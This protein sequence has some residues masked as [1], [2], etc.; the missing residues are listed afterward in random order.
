MDAAPAR[1]LA[2]RFHLWLAVA[3]LA[4]AGAVVVLV[5]LHDRRAALDEAERKAHLLLDRNLAIHRYLNR[6][7]KPAVLEHLERAPEA[8]FDS[9]WMS[10]S[11][12]VRRID[13]TAREEGTASQDFYYKESAID[14]RSPANEA[15]PYER[16]FL[17]DASRDP[18]LDVRSVERVVGG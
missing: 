6:E 11:Y 13:E 18:T 9:R 16:A 12:A 1:T 5:N 17:E 14:A 2:A 8:R 3:Y 7:L 15:D 10:P 4:A